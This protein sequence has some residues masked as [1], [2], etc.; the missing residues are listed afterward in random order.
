MP[1]SGESA[2]ARSPWSSQETGEGDGK[3]KVFSSSNKKRSRDAGGAVLIL[4]VR[5][6]TGRIWKSGKKLF[7]MPQVMVT[8]LLL[9]KH[10]ILSCFFATKSQNKGP[11]CIFSGKNSCANAGSSGLTLN[12]KIHWEGNTHIPV[13]P[14]KSKPHGQS[15]WQATVLVTAKELDT[16]CNYTT[17]NK[18]E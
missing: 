5:P 15:V 7:L 3:R 10:C 12:R 4:L 18:L 9:F 11:W 8:Y 16:L 2:V 17:T 6:I 1:G 14:F 13:F